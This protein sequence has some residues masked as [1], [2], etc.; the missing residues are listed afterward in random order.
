MSMTLREFRKE[1]G[2]SLEQ[3]G[4]QIGKSKATLSDIENGGRCTPKLALEIEAHTDGLV[5]AAALSEEIALARA[6]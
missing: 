2:L 1:R 3:L 5:N 6:A 4:E